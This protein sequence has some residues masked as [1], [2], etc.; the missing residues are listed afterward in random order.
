LAMIDAFLQSS[1]SIGI[2]LEDDFSLAER[3][4]RLR[5]LERVFQQMGSYGSTPVVLLAASK[6]H[7]LEP[8]DAL[9]SKS[10]QECTTCSAYVLNRASAQRVKAIW[11][12]GLEHLRRTHDTTSYACD[13]YWKRLQPFY[14][15]RDKFSCQRPSEGSMTNVVA[16]FD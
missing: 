4:S 10:W 6:Y 2:F 1:S 12:E 13:R 3:A 9:V 5:D 16:N 14:V 8:V 7:E 11:T 15:V